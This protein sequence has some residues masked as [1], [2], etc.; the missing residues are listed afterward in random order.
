MVLIIATVAAPFH[1]AQLRELLLPITEHVRFDAAQIADL[2][3]GE[4]ALRGNGRKGFLQLNQ[5]AKGK[6]FKS[7]LSRKFEQRVTGVF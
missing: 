4:V 2:T 6:T 5:Y 7:T 1:W 3:N